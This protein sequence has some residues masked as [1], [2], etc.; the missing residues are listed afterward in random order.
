MVLG[1]PGQSV[2][3]HKPCRDEMV[4]GSGHGAWSV[5][6]PAGFALLHGS[7]G[8]VC[9][10]RSLWFWR[11]V[12]REVVGSG[13]FRDIHVPV[14]E[15][16]YEKDADGEIERVHREMRL[17]GAKAKRKFPE[18]DRTGGPSDAADIRIVHCVTM[19]RDV[20]PGAIGWRG[21]PWL[22]YY[23]SP[24]QKD[25]WRVKGYHELPYH[26]IEWKTRP[27]RAY[28]SGR[29]RTPSPT[30]RCSR[31]WSARIS[32]RRS[33]RRSRLCSPWTMPTSCPPTS[34]QRRALWRRDGGRAASV[35]PAQPGAE[36]AIVAGAKPQRREAIR[37]AFFFTILSL[38]NR[39]Q[40][41]ATEVQTFDMERLRQM[42]PFVERIQQE[43]LTPLLAR[44]F[45]LLQRAGVLPPPPDELSGE[46][47]S[48]EHV[49]PLA[50]LQQMEQ[51]RGVMNWVT[52]LASV[53][54]A[55]GD[56]S[57]I[58]NIDPDKVAAV[59]HH[60]A[61]APPDV[62]R[63]PD[64]IKAIREGRAQA[65]QQAVAIEQQQVQVE[66]AATASHAAQAASMA[67]KRAA[68]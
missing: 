8:L 30:T 44:R 46:A 60:T 47:L 61:G 32:W 36:P 28:P 64:A 15:I 5:A 24:D 13:R 52:S 11:A 33:L 41:T 43:G 7:A 51:A 12:F 34:R 39:P 14:S 27:G 58:D 17:K 48:I 31:R 23:C 26:I 63:D 10:S 21:M 37:Q 40:M 20:R 25:F 62:R 55:T 1:H 2:P 59:L 50:K 35:A 65:Q 56:A 67:Q 22:S 18:L 68:A 6:R 49:S 66:T 4:L 53:A 16:F 45:N 29:A 38:I 9:Q 54:Q 19:N 57:I 42:A 3:S